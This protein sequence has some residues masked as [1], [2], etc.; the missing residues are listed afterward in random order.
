MTSFLKAFDVDPLHN[1]ESIAFSDTASSYFPLMIGA[2]V[3]M[4]VG[5]LREDGRGKESG[6]EV[7]ANRGEE[8][9]GEPRRGSVE[10]AICPDSPGLCSERGSGGAR[11]GAAPGSTGRGTPAW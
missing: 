10:A 6:R 3:A 7:G 8:W 2:V 5:S 9:S 1:L 11:P 4:E